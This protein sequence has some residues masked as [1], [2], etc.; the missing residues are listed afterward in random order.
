MFSICFN[1]NYVL[2]VFSAFYVSGAS[3][4]HGFAMSYAYLRW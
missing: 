1:P 3:T 4:N 2:L